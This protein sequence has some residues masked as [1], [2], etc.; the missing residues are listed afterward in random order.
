MIARRFSAPY[1]LLLIWIACL[2]ACA[3]ISAPEPP[4][5]LVPKPATDLR[6][7]QYADRIMLTV[8]MPVE[9]TNGSRVATLR[10]VEILR[11]ARDR[12]DTVP[13]PQ[14]A[15]LAQA[16]PIHSIRAEELGPYLKNGTLTLPDPTAADADTFYKQGLLYAVRFINK[17]NQTAGLSNQVFVAPVA[18]PLPPTGLASTPFRDHIRLTWQPAQKNADGSAPAR[19]IGYNVYRSEEPKDFPPTPLNAAPLPGPEFEDRNFEFDKTYYYAITV[20]G[21]TENPYAESLPSDPF[22]VST[23]DT[24]PPGMPRNLAFAV[25]KGVVLLLWG[26]PDDTDV[27][28]YRVYRKEEGASARVLLQ[29]QLVTTLSFR[30][31]QAQS[32]K[33]YEYSVT[34]VDTHGNE[35]PAATITLEVQ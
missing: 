19:V 25:E 16:E 8:S 9:N 3:K 14:D 2:G 23:Q 18:I 24:F 20:V 7:R 4:H 11:L 28:G 22:K 5:A 33:K 17:K 15:F 26:P 32:G 34:A 1:C 31:S 10:E 12:G 6:A 21:S 13:L 30:D 35:G 29:A 27:A